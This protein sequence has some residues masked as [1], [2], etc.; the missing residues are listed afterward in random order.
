M[1]AHGHVVSVHLVMFTIHLPS[2][3]HNYDYKYLCNRTIYT[4]IGQVIIVWFNDCILG[5][6]DQIN[7][8][9]AGAAEGSESW[10]G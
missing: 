9:L 4:I 10:Y 7:L 2:L 8:I 5:K 1:N 6:S 3:A